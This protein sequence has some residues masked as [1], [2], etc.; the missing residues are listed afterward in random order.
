MST[1]HSEHRPDLLAYLD[2]ASGPGGDVVDLDPLDWSVPPDGVASATPGDL[3]YV[4]ALQKRFSYEVGFV[5]RAALARKIE[6]GRVHLAREN[7]EPCGYVHHGSF[8]NKRTPNEARI[9]QAA[10]QLDA[11]HRHHGLN[12][13]GRVAAEAEAAGIHTLTARC[14]SD[15]DANAFWKQAGFR[16]AGVERGSKGPLIVWARRLAP[17][18]D[19]AEGGGDLSPVSRRLHPCPACGAMTTDTWTP[20]PRRHS[21]CRACT[22]SLLRA[23][24]VVAGVARA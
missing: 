1:P 15:L 17:F 6:L 24:D 4:V 5:Q 21:T 2:A 11:Q 18:Y 10:V 20:G 3:A 22:A 9:F 14:L 19:A 7:G 16:R 13:V 23:G 12:L 8:A